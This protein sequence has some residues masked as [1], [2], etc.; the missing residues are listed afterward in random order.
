[1]RK[2]HAQLYTQVTGRFQPCSSASTSTVQRILACKECCQIQAT[3]AVT[4]HLA[5]AVFAPLA[6]FLL[7][8][9]SRCL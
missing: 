5:S 9:S 3:A 7:I 2:A 6:L 4:R 1:M 8:F